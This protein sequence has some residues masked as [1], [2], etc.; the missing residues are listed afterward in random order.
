MGEYGI[1]FFIR[2]RFFENLKGFEGT[3]RPAGGI[4]ADGYVGLRTVRY[5]FP[6]REGTFV[7]LCVIILN[8]FDDGLLWPCLV[9][10]LLVLLE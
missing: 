10:S 2:Q 5:G 6:F 4:G 1:D 8:R 7:K 3:C 9:C